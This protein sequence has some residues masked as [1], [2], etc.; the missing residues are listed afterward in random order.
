MLRSLL[1]NIKR[2]YHRWCLTNAIAHHHM[3]V[4]IYHASTNSY[5]V[6]SPKTG[7]RYHVYVDDCGKIMFKGI[8][9]E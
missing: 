1:I 8:Q 4:C 3:R 9:Y 5:T 7:H 2:T 6:E